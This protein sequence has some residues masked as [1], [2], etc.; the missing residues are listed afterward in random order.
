MKQ[1]AA[2]F[3][4][5]LEEAIFFF[6]SLEFFSARTFLSQLNLHY[7]ARRT[8]LIPFNIKLLN[9]MQF[10]HLSLGIK[11][12]INKQKSTDVQLLSKKK[13]Y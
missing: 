12:V 11:I 5:G 3:F 4:L 13:K 2:S 7:R 8:T 9:C 10:K 1:N 6:P